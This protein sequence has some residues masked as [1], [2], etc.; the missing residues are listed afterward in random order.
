MTEAEMLVKDQKQ[1]GRASPYWLKLGWVKGEPPKYL[2][3]HHMQIPSLHSISV[4][5]SVIP[6]E[7]FYQ[8]RTFTINPQ[9][10]LI[11]LAVWL[12]LHI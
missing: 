10:L 3:C 6:Q 2:I 1:D 11:A 7:M 9:I 5:G 8:N 12:I 4:N